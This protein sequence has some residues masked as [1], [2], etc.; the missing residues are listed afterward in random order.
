MR[1]LLILALSLTACATDEEVH[2]ASAPVA[3]KDSLNDSTPA[4]EPLGESVPPLEVPEGYVAQAPVAFS[5]GGMGS[6]Y[7]VVMKDG[8]VVDTVETYFGVHEVG[9]DSLFA[10]AVRTA[11][12]PYDD[13]VWANPDSFRLYTPHGATAIGRSLPDF[14]EFFSSP[15]V[16][17]RDLF[18]WGLGTAAED[19]WRDLIAVRYGFGGSKVDS[20]YLGRYQEHGTD[21]WHYFTPPHRRGSRIVYELRDRE[22]EVDPQSWEVV[23]RVGA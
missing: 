9:R 14:S 10:W 2:Q 23:A 22:W 5:S 3:A 11:N 16:I 20:T 15:A 7:A 4:S 6:R 13:E 19:G 1:L 8:S 12:N 18:Y 17:D 21:H